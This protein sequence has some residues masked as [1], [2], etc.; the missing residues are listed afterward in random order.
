MRRASTAASAIVALLAALAFTSAAFAEDPDAPVDGTRF[1]EAR[2]AARA[3]DF[4]RARTLYAD[5]VREHPNDVDYVFGYAQVLAWLGDPE[6]S[7][8]LLEEARRLAPDY[9]DVWAL[10]FR[11]R[12][13]RH[14][15]QYRDEDEAFARA[16]AERFPDAKW[17]TQAAPRPAGEWRWRVAAERERLSNG[18]PDWQ[19]YSASFSWRPGDGRQISLTANRATRFGTTDDA[20]GADA[21]IEL[22]DRW[23]AGAAAAFS[24]APDFLP[25]AAFGLS[26]S[27]KL[28]HGWVVN[29]RLRRRAYPDQSVGTLEVGAE[30]Y[31]GKY[32]FEYAV[33]ESRLGGEQALVQRIAADRY[34]ADG[35]RLGLVLASGEEIEAVGPGQLLRTRVWSVAVTGA[36]VLDGRFEIGWW[37]GTHEQGD[38][39]RRDAIGVSVSG[40]F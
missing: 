3:G 39:Y 14:D 1:Q 27:R 35:G 26:L 7:L 11:L 33:G 13:V 5:L 6:A 23:I 8:P 16:A 31:V 30:R 20:L 34:A 9:E 2:E 28:E 17:L 18:A 38:L 15:R 4:E 12:Q 36:Y 10:E 19:N 40:V 21:S 25:E 32:R 22:N 37:L 29:G 24:S